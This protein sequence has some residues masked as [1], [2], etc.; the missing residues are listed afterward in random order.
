[1]KPTLRSR[2]LH[3]VALSAFGLNNACGGGETAPAI[4]GP[5]EPIDAPAPP[6]AADDPDATPI[7]T[8]ES[9]SDPEPVVFVNNVAVIQGTTLDFANDH[10]T[11]DCASVDSGGPDRVYRITIPTNHRLTATVTP[12]AGTF[13]PGI[14]LLAAPAATCAV[15]PTVC[16]AFADQGGDGMTDTLQHINP[17]GG[18]NVDV[19]LIVDTFRPAGNAYTLNL[20][21][22]FDP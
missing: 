14:F 1:M 6:D 18:A 5:T 10:M 11:G 12:I 20:A 15:V 19:F 8:G 17:I 13:D 16:L 22:E 21:L 2:L 7:P 9:C 4:D 3:C